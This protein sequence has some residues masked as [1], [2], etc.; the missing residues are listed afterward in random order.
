MLDSVFNDAIVAYPSGLSVDDQFEFFCADKLLTNYDV[1]YAEISDGIIDGK[2]DG[3]VDSAYLF[4]DRRLV[5]TD[6][7]YKSVGEEPEVELILIQSKNTSSFGEV[8]VDKLT[9]LL[10][11]F[12]FNTPTATTT[13]ALKQDVIDVFATFKT[14]LSKV[15]SKFPKVMIHA[16][17]CAR[18]G[19]PA[20]SI[21]GKADALQTA[22]AARYPASTVS[23]IGAARLYE[24]AREQKTF[25]K[26]LP[27]AVPPLNVQNALVGLVKLSDFAAF[28]TDDQGG[29]INRIFES[30]VRDY[31]GDIEVNRE[32]AASLQTGVATEFWWLNNGVTIVADKAQYEHPN[33][34]IRNPLI[35]N[36]LQTS[37]EIHSQGAN[38][39]NDARNV[40]VKI[41]E[42]TDQTEREKIIRATNRQTAIQSSSF[43]ATDAIHVKIDDYLKG[44]GY[45]YDRRKNSYKRQGKAA[46]RIIGIDRLAQ[47]V[48]AVLLQRPEVARARPGTALKKEAD[49]KAIF[50][51]DVDHPMQMY[52]VVTVLLMQVE[53]H[54][55][56][57]RKS[58][59]RALVNNMKFHVLMVLSWTLNGNSTLPG[60]RIGQLDPTTVDDA[61]LQRVATWVFS[62][63]NDFGT[64]DRKAR[65]PKFT[66]R[67]KDNWT[68]AATAY[69]NLEPPR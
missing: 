41:I 44:Q 34:T 40:L 61:M 11:A 21:V 27:A 35:V 13:A 16:Y 7:D 56:S 9:S 47:A 67:L 59:D 29:I 8:P 20:T 2:G 63:F 23:L 39:I 6:F 48:L 26:A 17:Y 49:Y 12:V 32:I 57:I 22:L 1:S 62:E 33:I 19:T 64:A 4:I 46:D 45:F 3:G 18:A 25:T 42:E 10:S 54:F 60:I 66:K 53:A 50:S 58:T 5:T 37:F 65:D 43:R 36:G 31:Q 24:L 69:R 51:E 55:R 38:L 30:N 52:H 15:G 68:K 28:V 14:A